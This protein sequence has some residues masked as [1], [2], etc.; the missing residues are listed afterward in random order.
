MKALFTILGII[1]GGLA[2]VFVIVSLLGTPGSRSNLTDSEAWRMSCDA[3]QA[4][5]KSPSTAVFP[6]ASTAG[7]AKD[8]DRTIITS[9]VDSQ[10]SFGGIVRT[11]WIVWVKKSGGR[12]TSAK[13]VGLESRR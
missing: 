5:L 1:V 6:S 12:Y 13:V 2:V 9:F 10:N 8:T 4:S 11:D 7:W 3:V